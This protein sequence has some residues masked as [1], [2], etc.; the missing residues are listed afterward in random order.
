MIELWSSDIRTGAVSDVLDLAYYARPLG[1]RFT[2]CGRL[3]ERFIRLATEEGLD[4]ISGQSRFISKRGSLLYVFAVIAWLWRLLRLRPDVVH[5]NYVGYAPSLACAARFLRI[6]IVARAG[7]VFGTRKL[8]DR[9]ANR[10]IAAYV[11]N[12]EAQAASLLASPLASRVSVVGDLFRP[13]RVTGAE[14]EQRPI[15]P[16][17]AGIPRLLFLGQLVERK[18]L[19]YLV[20]AFAEMKSTAELL[21]VGG[22][23]AESGY[24]EKI[25][26]LIKQ[27]G[28]SDRVKCEN[29]RTDIGALFAVSDIL[30]LASLSEGRPRCIIEAM[31]AG[32]PVIAT[33]VGGIPSLID[34]GTNG[35]LIPPSDVDA[36]AR[37]M[38]QLCGSED[39]R[40]RLGETGLD[41]AQRRLRPEV[42]A[43]KYV[44]LYHRLAARNN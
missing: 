26:R 24:P 29:H 5:L 28:M 16:R 15:P 43:E 31:L 7:G 21:L 11:A 27:L 42:T 6:P 2:L 38:D 13:Q 12:C 22:D 18:G 14:S 41:G 33:T 1:A 35:L 40:R 36:L 17:A 34:N 25:R 8:A 20:R 19:E 30:V 39:L 9:L 23:W 32:L 3:D 10:W 44:D 37:A 4:T